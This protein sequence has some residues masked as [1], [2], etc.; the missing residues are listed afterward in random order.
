MSLDLAPPFAHAPHIPLE[1]DLLRDPIHHE[2]DSLTDTGSH[3]LEIGH[4]TVL[5][6]CRV[7]HWC[8][9]WFHRT[10]LAVLLLH[11][12]H[13]IVTPITLTTLCINAFFI[14]SQGCNGLFVVGAFLL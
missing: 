12:K 5:D 13:S 10:L 11:V 9:L 14:A 8:N 7:G 3:E 4:N 1:C 2:Y 6:R